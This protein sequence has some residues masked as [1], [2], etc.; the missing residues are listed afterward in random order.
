[1]RKAWFCYEFVHEERPAPVVYYDYLPVASASGKENIKPRVQL[2]EI[3]HLTELNQPIPS[4]ITLSNM[5]PYKPPL[6][7]PHQD[8]KEI[9]MT[10]PV[11]GFQT[12]QG[13]FFDTEE[14]ANLYEASFDLNEA[15]TAAVRSFEPETIGDFPIED[16]LV[17]GI[18]SFI[19]SNEKL[20]SK[21]L[22]ARAAMLRTTSETSPSVD[23]PPAVSHT[24]DD[25]SVRSEDSTR[26][27]DETTTEGEP[28]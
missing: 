22:N 9:V 6:K 28:T 21:Y 7:I 3:S 16:S 26:L 18:T 17:K 2:V 13:K 11:S 8:A 10:R 4:L 1:M 24:P 20:I 23:G 27:D 25:T 12:S 5:Y 15:T 14:E 19:A